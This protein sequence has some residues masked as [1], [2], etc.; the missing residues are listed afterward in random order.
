M[1]A[2]NTK[3]CALSSMF[4]LQPVSVLKMLRLT[5]LSSNAD[6]SLLIGF[7]LL[8]YSANLRGAML[9]FLGAVIE[10]YPGTAFLLDS[11]GRQL[12]VQPI[13]IASL[14]VPGTV[15]EGTGDSTGNR[16]V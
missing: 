9:G 14:Y 15:V 16:T 6:I 3:H 7:S 8:I 10:S 2:Q 1:Q 5:Q 4:H 12:Y 11:L 13:F